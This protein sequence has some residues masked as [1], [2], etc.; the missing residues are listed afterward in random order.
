MQVA[1]DGPAGSGKSSVCKIIAEKYSFTYI[2][3]GAMYRSIAWLSVHFGEENLAAKA[4]NT[5]FILEN[6]GRKISIKYNGK[7]YDLTKEIRTPEI[8]SKVAFA[9]SN[10]DIR[11]ILVKK[12]QSYAEGCDVIME[13]RDITT[14]VL[15][16]ADIKIFLT[17]SPE[18]RAKRRFKEW[19]G[20]AE[21]AEYTKVL[22]EIKKRDE[23]DMTR[24]ESPLMQSEDAVLL[25]TTGLSLEQVAD[26]IGEM[27]ISYNHKNKKII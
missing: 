15:P 19:E 21:A 27:I 24:K 11:K 22:E 26:K 23:I 7:I 8:S 17:A 16:D 2:D 6:N 4:E 10:S 20:M 18:E 12:Q 13:G 3:T 5:E 14:V 25:D 1:I 9:A